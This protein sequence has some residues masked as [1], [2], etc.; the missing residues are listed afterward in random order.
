MDAKT[1]IAVRVIIDRYNTWLWYGNAGLRKVVREK[2]GE[3]AECP[4]CNIYNSN[5]MRC[6]RDECPAIDTFELCYNQE[7]FDKIQWMK[8]REARFSFITVRK[9]LKE[10]IE[11]YEDKLTK[12]E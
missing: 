4:L 6:L 2:F 9:A 8:I 5:E 10:R 3:R 1:K 12:E 7:W 11:Y